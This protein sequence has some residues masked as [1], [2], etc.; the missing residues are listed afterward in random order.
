M[1]NF[2]GFPRIEA[3]I[4]S[5]F[6]P[7]LG[8]K[9]IHE[10]PEGFTTPMT[11]PTLNV[12]TSPTVSQGRAYPSSPPQ[13]VSAIGSESCLYLGQT[14][15]FDSIS[16]YI[17]PKLEICNRLVIISTRNYKVVGYP[18]S[19][20]SQKYERNA[21]LFNM[22]FVF[23]RSEDVSPFVPI[24]KKLAGILKYVEVRINNTF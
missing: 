16:E 15:D 10:V 7:L 1:D 20:Q 6:H 19:I 22:S 14:L 5:E 12:C 2:Q 24:V 23:K 11:S 3:I 17:I 4:Y 13:R 21:L 8:P 18:V 9:V